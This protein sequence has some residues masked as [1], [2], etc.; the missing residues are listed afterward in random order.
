[1]KREE[2][3]DEENDEEVPLSAYLSDSLA[4]CDRYQNTT[5]ALLTCL[6]LGSNGKQVLTQNK[7]VAYKDVEQPLETDKVIII[8]TGECSG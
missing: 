2:A 1:M 3:N 5:N 7:L 6:D 4:L 8:R